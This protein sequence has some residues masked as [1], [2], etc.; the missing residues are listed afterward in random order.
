MPITLISCVCA[1]RLIS[2]KMS[3]AKNQSTRGSKSSVVE[4]LNNPTLFE[5]FLS[6]EDAIYDFQTNHWISIS[7]DLNLF[8]RHWIPILTSP[9]FLDSLV[10]ILLHVLMKKPLHPNLHTIPS[11]AL[12]LPRT[13]HVLM[14]FLN[15]ICSPFSVTYFYPNVF[16]IPKIITC[17]LLQIL[18]TKKLS[19]DP[20]TL[21]SLLIVCWV[22]I[23]FNI[24][25]LLPYLIIT[26]PNKHINNFH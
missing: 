21:I 22:S 25:L 9:V 10:K 20:S 18:F 16:S 3:M 8:Q 5:T 23:L 14:L 2:T 13:P 4:N 11:R 17:M 15:H 1:S 6:F 7:P 12:P 19:S 24:A 26:Y